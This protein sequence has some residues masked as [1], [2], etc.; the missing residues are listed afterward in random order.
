MTILT[1][2]LEMFDWATDINNVQIYKKEC[3][4][5]AKFNDINYIYRKFYF[6]I[7]YSR[8]PNNRAANLILFE[9]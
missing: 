1:T 3:D 5:C 8:V 7:Q 6:Q 2:L 9:K 4:G